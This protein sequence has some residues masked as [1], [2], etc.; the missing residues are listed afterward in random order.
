M[1]SQADPA[2]SSVPSGPHILSI[3]VCGVTND[4]KENAVNLAPTRD[5]NL[6]LEE[7]D[8]PAIYSKSKFFMLCVTVRP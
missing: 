5:L 1:K 7:N 2:R 3:A 6:E 8:N 4:V